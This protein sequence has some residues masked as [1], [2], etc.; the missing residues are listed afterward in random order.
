[1]A[2]IFAV[3]SLKVAQVHYSIHRFL[4]DML[5]NETEGIL[6]WCLEGL[7]RL[8]ENG[9]H[10]SVSERME[11]NRKEIMEEQNNIISFMESVGYIEY[12]Q[13]SKTPSLDIFNA[14]SKWCKDNVEEPQEKR[15]FCIYLKTHAERYNIK[16]LENIPQIG[17]KKRV[18]GYRGIRI[19]QDEESTLSG[20][21]EAQGES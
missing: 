18:R 6:L 13:Q 12:T 16:Y 5:D 8:I 20:G 11:K 10:F 3:I 15:T 1:M 4:C 7:K 19:L 21:H 2:Q 9:F 17:E 14:Y